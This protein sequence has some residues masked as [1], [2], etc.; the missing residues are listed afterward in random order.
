MTY[1][2]VELVVVYPYVADAST[3]KCMRGGRLASYKVALT[4]AVRL[5]ADAIMTD[6]TSSQAEVRPQA[7]NLV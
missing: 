4:H 5:L 1:I 3:W 2:V 7:S 6:I